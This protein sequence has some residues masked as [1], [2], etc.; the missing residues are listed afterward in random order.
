MAVFSVDSDAVLAA[1]TLVRG[2]VD[3]LQSEASTLHAQLAQLQ[4]VW[5]GTAAV[6]FHGAADQWHAA[7]RQVE[8][9]LA[10]ISTAL[11]TAGRQYA[12]AEQLSA[13]LF[14]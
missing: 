8:E 11:A 4:S 5:T 2:T 6:A 14:R 12:E 10:T 3:R 9:S 1:T 13:S 7:H